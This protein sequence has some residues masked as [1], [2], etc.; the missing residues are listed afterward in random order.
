MSNLGDRDEQ[1]FKF[2]DLVLGGDADFENDRTATGLDK[3]SIREIADS[4]KTHG[5][6]NRIH[7]WMPPDGPNKGKII[8]WA[9]ERRFR[10]ISMLIDQGE[11]PK[12]K[13][14]PCVVRRDKVADMLKL[15]VAAL[16]ENI[17]R[18][19]LNGLEIAR[20]LKRL[21]DAG[22]K[23]AEIAKL[24]KRSQTY[25]SQH[26]NALAKT[27]PETQKAWADGKITDIQAFGL[28]KVEDPKKQNAK[29][30]E[31]V[32]L[33]E[34][35]GRK[36]KGEANKVAKEAS[37]E[38]EKEKEEK[39]DKPTASE[40]RTLL[41]DLRFAASEHPYVKGLLDMLL[42]VE[43]DE[44]GEGFDE[45]FFTEVMS[46]VEERNAAELEAKAAKKAQ[47]TE[48]AEK[49]EPNDDWL[50]EGSPETPEV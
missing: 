40:R 27:T 7:V 15:R 50:D 14:I 49:R 37:G 45:P 38:K 28:M 31:V 30:D 34:D 33:R 48:K 4:I 24:I 17:D 13:L 5:L 9:G 2:N 16:V 19:D 18:Q 39:I 29:L 26:L 41:D 23:Q 6:F 47:N 44:E 42:W 11:W 8:V 32:A 12:E 43:A 36:K 25:V 22:K 3:K 46:K 10:A 20:S 1:E 21:S 35:G